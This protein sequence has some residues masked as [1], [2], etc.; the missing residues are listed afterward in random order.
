MDSQIM[1]DFLKGKTILVTG[2]TG[3]LAKV[4]V[5]KILRIQPEIQKMYLLLRA[6][7][8]QCA[9]ER[10]QNEVFKIDLFRVLRER[11][12]ENFSSFISKKVVTIAGDVAKENLGIKDEKLKNDMFEEIDFLV[13]FAAS[14]KFN[15]RFDI[16]MDVNTKG[17]LNVLNIAKNCRRL[18]AFGHISTAYVCG[19]AKDGHGILQEKP[20]EMGQSLKKDSKLDIH[21]EMDL[22]KRKLAELQAMNVDE[23][24][25]KCVM[26]DYGMERANFHGWPN[27]YTFT[28]AMG[29]MLLMHKKDNVP[30]IIIRPTMITSTRKDPFPGWIEGLRTID[31]MIYGYGHGKI[32]FFLGNPNT[33]MDAI[34]A[35]M[36]INCV[37]T[38]IFFHS[39]EPPKNFIY[40]ISSSLRNP[41]KSSDLHNICHHYFMKTPCI[42]QNG[43][44]IIISKG[45]VVNSFA[46]FNIFMIIRFVLLLMVL[47]LVNKICRNS[48]KDVYDNQSR[49][50]RVLQHL[51]KLYK[52]YAYFN[53]IFDD[54]NVEILRMATKVNLKTKNDELDFDPTSFDWK[55]YMMNIHIPGLLKYHKK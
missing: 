9:E 21:K 34:P 40:H 25:M 41:I 54:T 38:A 44:P 17:A 1:K 8:T 35:D 2:A 46:A 12:G 15:E 4:F 49:K 33:I 18:K 32:K 52:P 23:N 42:N 30:L 13:H 14:T 36:V 19:D 7:N 55:D 6:S 43:K 45:I 11:W 20:F 3:F 24:S 16:L 37:M 31:S 48:F 39:N 26:Q 47:N 50:F 28:K 53:S 29:E 27:T 10:L 22:I 5:E 51:A